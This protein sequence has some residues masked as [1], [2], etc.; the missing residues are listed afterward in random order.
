M[1]KDF[2]DT[3]QFTKQELLDIIEL[4]LAIK[5]AIKLYKSKAYTVSEITEMTG[6]KKTTLYKHL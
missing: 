3:N 5:K 2:I 4:S 6:V 1:I